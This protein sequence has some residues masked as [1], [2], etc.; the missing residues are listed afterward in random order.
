MMALLLLDP[1]LQRFRS[2]S[3]GQEIKTF[4]AVDPWE[5]LDRAVGID[6]RG[7]DRG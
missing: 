1:T 4:L 5:V 7:G 2:I 3:G 6:P